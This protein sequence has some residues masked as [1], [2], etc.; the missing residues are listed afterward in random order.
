MIETN[1]YRIEK[2]SM[3]EVRVLQ[4]ALWGAQTQRAME[5]FP[6][7]GYRIPEP[8]I[9]ALALIKRYA[10]EVNCELGEMD[11]KLA[12]AIIKASEEIIRGDHIDQFPLDVF[13]TG[14]G[15]STNMNMNEVISNRANEI[16]GYPRG[17]RYPVHPN[18]HV[19]R[20][21]SSNDD[22]PA[23]IHIAVREQL[24]IRLVPALAALHKELSQKAE[25]FQNIVKIG[26]T[27]L[28]D[29]V[30]MTLG[31]EFS[32]YAEQVRKAV[33]RI[34]TTYSRI[35][36]LALGGTAVGT[37]L[38]SK[39]GF[40]PRVIARIAERT[41]IP[42]RQAENLFESLAARDAIVEVNGALN[43]VAVSLTKI[44]NDLRI[45]NSGPRTALGEITLPSLQ[46]GSSIMPGK[47]NPV[48]AE[49]MIQVAAYVMGH[50][51]TAT[52]A[53][54]SGLLDL[55]VMK[56]LLAYITIES[57]RVLSEAVNVFAEKA[58][59]GLKANAER[60]AELVEWS[61]ALVTPLAL[62]IGYDRAAQIAYKAFQERK[63]VRKIIEEEGILEPEEI[64]KVLDPRSMLSPTD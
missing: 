37:G 46:P 62:K 45:L 55:H 16:L 11:S 1:E 10:A 28:M 14:S 64:E 57:I 13:Q 29:A 32:G 56:P 47:V 6:I 8:M 41:G 27:H 2:D 61:M 31:Q 20:G 58:V 30:P 53:G 42:F 3:G 15:T 4:R 44:A 54:Q 39:R 7:S 21:Q 59:R 43:T 33:E 52:I 49:M 9:R 50:N 26:R 5:N 48:I 17:E 24:G 36:E 35:E 63:S 38:N 18:D 60:C 22:I 34:E 19:N 40:A 25:S 12:E 23:A 51:F